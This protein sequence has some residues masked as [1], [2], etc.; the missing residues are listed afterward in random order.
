ME[1]RAVSGTHHAWN[2]NVDTPLAQLQQRVDAME[3]YVDPLTGN[4]SSLA[5]RASTASEENVS[6]LARERL[7]YG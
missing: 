1:I 3:K 4:G 7:Y 5:G 2:T 6:S